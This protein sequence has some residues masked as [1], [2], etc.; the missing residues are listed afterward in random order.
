MSS[1]LEHDDWKIRLIQK[2]IYLA[3]LI[4]AFH[5]KNNNEVD[6]IKLINSITVVMLI[7]TALLVSSISNSFIGLIVSFVL[8]NITYT[9][10]AERI[11]LMLIVL[12]ESN[13]NNQN[14]D[15]SGQH[16]INVDVAALELVD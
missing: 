15:D 5:K 6:P 7:I 13:L 1:T 4:S 16:K 14:T 3:E 2:L 10:N 11:K 8:L 9:Q 12:I